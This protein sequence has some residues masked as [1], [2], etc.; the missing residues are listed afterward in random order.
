MEPNPVLKACNLSRKFKKFEAR[1]LNL[2][3]DPGEIVVLQGHNGSGKTT[4]LNCLSYLIRQHRNGEVAALTWSNKSR[5]PAAVC[6]C[7]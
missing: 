1:P 3:I 4:L 6:L 5:K 7:P 2:T